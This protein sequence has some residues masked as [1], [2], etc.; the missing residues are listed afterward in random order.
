MPNMEEIFTKTSLEI[1]RLRTVQLFISKFDLKY[2]YRQNKRSD[3]T[4]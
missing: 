3:E 2:A 1:T 4:N